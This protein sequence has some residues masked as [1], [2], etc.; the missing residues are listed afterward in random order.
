MSQIRCTN[1]FADNESHNPTGYAA[2]ATQ[3]RSHISSASKKYYLS[4]APQCP[5]PDASMPLDMC[6]QMDFVWVQFYNNGDCNNGQSGFDGAVKQWSSGIGSAEL[7]IGAVASSSD[8]DQGYI[9]A[10]QFVSELQSVQGMGLSNY[11]GA[12]LWEAQLAVENG[13]YQQAV[14]AVV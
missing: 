3:F 7:F 1:T 10:S 13:N 11:G 9:P 8:G 5:Y 6:T 14:G 12:M 2:M 4:A